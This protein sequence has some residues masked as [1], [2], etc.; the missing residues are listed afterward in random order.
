M[1]HRS[2]VATCGLM[3][4]QNEE[5]G[6]TLL[7]STKGTPVGAVPMVL[8]VRAEASVSGP[9]TRRS[10]RSRALSDRARRLSWRNGDKSSSI[11]AAGEAAHARGAEGTGRWARAIAASVTAQTV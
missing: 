11:A 1:S 6:R 4:C 9:E 7:G 2:Q 10:R 5:A 3:L 8:A